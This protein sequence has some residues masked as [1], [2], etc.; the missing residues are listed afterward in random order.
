MSHVGML[1]LW[2]EKEEIFQRGVAAAEAQADALKAMARRLTKA[3]ATT[4][5]S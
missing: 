1:S 5:T 4:E 3:T 2:E